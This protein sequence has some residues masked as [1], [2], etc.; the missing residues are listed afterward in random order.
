MLKDV[1]YGSHSVASL[2]TT[3][4]S[5]RHTRR[6]CP[7]WA[8]SCC[9]FC[10]AIKQLPRR[11]KYRFGQSCSTLVVFCYILGISYYFMVSADH[12]LTK[13]QKIAPPLIGRTFLYSVDMPLFSLPHTIRVGNFQCLCRFTITTSTILV[14][15]ADGLE[16]L[17]PVSTASTAPP[18]WCVPIV[19]HLR[20]WRWLLI[21]LIFLYGLALATSPAHAGGPVFGLRALAPPNDSIPHPTR[22]LERSQRSTT[23][24]ARLLK[25]EV[26]FLYALDESTNR[27]LFLG[28]RNNG[29]LE[30]TREPKHELKVQVHSYNSQRKGSPQSAMVMS[31]KTGRWFVCLKDSVISIMKILLGE[32]LPHACE[33][34]GS[35]DSLDIRIEPLAG[36]SRTVHLEDPKSPHRQ[37]FTLQLRIFAEVKNTTSEVCT[38]VRSSLRFAAQKDL[39]EAWSLLRNLTIAQEKLIGALVRGGAQSRTAG[40][41]EP[42]IDRLVQ[43]EHDLVIVKWEYEGVKTRDQGDFVG[44]SGCLRRVP[45]TLEG[46]IPAY[47]NFRTELRKLASKQRKLFRSLFDKTKRLS[48]WSVESLVKYR[49]RPSLTRILRGLKILPETAPDLEP[50]LYL[51]ERYLPKE[52]ATEYSNSDFDPMERAI[53]MKLEEIIVRGRL[54]DSHFLNHLKCVNDWMERLPRRRPKATCN[55]GT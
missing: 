6:Y 22:I 36:Q 29:T 34:T 42:I 45:R 16:I 50:K 3:P 32:D 52:I 20:C 5:V 38:E 40:E 19:T 25:S 15:I 49:N 35:E 55:F 23:D 11:V 2:A 18:Q 7:R 30:I 8:S 21:S 31:A 26:G 41:T 47:V 1:K 4:I 43:L 33:W 51:V 46:E 14:L 44:I 48:V 9:N 53:L 37:N 17:P 10:R 12:R 27:K 13:Y 28:V 54:L 39:T 24:Y